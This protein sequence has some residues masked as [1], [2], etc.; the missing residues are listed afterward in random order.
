MLGVQHI[1]LKKTVL[2][3]LASE[4]S[5][6]ICKYLTIIGTGH[7]SIYIYI[8]IELIFCFIYRPMKIKYSMLAYL[9]PI[10]QAS[11]SATRDSKCPTTDSGITSEEV[12]FLLACSSRHI[13]LIYS[14]ST[15]FCI[16]Q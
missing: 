15:N 3:P 4:L 9:S 14:W 7:I 6:C 8:D 16:S 2:G 1:S 12:T 11:E 10:A 5:W 13:G